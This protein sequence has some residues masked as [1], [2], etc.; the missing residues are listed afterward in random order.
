QEQMDPR[1][2]THSIYIW[3]GTF[4]IAESV[5]NA[6]F[7]A[8]VAKLQALHGAAYCR[9]IDPERL[10]GAKQP[11]PW[12]LIGKIQ[13]LIFMGNR[14]S[15]DWHEHAGGQTRVTVGFQY[16]RPVG[17]K[18]AAGTCRTSTFEPE[19]LHFRSKRFLKTLRAGHEDWKYF[20]GLNGVWPM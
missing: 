18:L 8:Q 16:A 6:I 7:G 13:Y 17:M 9:G 10:F 4:A 11:L 15:R 20:G 2:W 12:G 19:C 5:A 3:A 14:A 1:V